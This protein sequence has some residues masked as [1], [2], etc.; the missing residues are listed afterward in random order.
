MEQSLKFA[1]QASN[2][3]AEYKALLARMRL[4]IDMGVKRLVVRSDSQLVMEQ[5]AENFQTRDP[6]LAKP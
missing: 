1:F 6:H 3:Q 2:N 4:A 5:V